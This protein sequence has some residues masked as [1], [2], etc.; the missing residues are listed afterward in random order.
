VCDSNR[1]NFSRKVALQTYRYYPYRFLTDFPQ[2]GDHAQGGI[3]PHYGTVL[4]NDNFFEM[5]VI[6]RSRDVFAMTAGVWRTRS[7][8]GEAGG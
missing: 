8:I 7:N 1:S 6:Q 2:P 3:R 5:C 4:L